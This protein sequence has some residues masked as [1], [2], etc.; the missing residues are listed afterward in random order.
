MGTVEKDMHIG[1]VGGGNMA[2]AI[3]SGMVKSGMVKP[4]DIIASSKS[5]QRKPVWEELEAKFT[6]DNL[7]VVA[8]SHIV[9]LCVKPHLMTDVM[10]QISPAVG[11]QVFVSV[12]AGITIEHMQKCL[13]FGTNVIRTM[14]NTPCL[15]QSGVVVYSLSQHCKQEDGE[16]VQRLLETCGLVMQVQENQIDSMSSLMGCSPAWY[17][18]V[19][20]AMSDG[21][22]KC[23]VPRAQSYALAAKAMEG[24][25][26]MVLQTGKHPGQL[27]DE[28]T[29]PAG[30]TICGV[31]ALE[32]G[33]LRGVF[34]NAVQAATDR[35]R[36]LGA[37]AK[38]KLDAAES[39]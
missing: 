18:M 26:K 10:K 14:P 24:A 19:L 29:S 5:E 21:G 36:E 6:T 7:A 4:M 20:E 33:G 39:N 9:F 30:S 1:F 23:G 38:A 13:P 12:A 16:K 3:A 2:Y 31:N 25:A 37:A 28:V 15:V 35:N 8:N 11:A 32:Q 34:I 17:Y 27:K 22:V